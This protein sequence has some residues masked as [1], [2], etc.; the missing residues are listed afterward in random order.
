[1][2]DALTADGEAVGVIVG[3]LD[4][5]EDEGQFELGIADD[6]I[7]DE[8]LDDGSVDGLLLGQVDEGLCELGA[9]DGWV[10]GG[11][12]EEWDIL[13]HGDDGK[14]VVG[15]EFD[16]IDDD[17]NQVDAFE[18]EGVEKEGTDDRGIEDDGIEEVATEA[19]GGDDGVKVDALYQ[20]SVVWI[21]K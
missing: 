12:Q 5:I 9:H 8:G 17:G 18:E 2:S 15:I 1:M 13:G 3:K 20:I 4:G 19:V 7:T 16:G 11:T 10:E 14:L 6:G 21:F